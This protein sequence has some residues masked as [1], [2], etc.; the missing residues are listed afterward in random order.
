MVSLQLRDSVHPGARSESNA[1][2]HQQPLRSDVWL[3]LQT[4]YAQ[5]L[6]RGRDVKGKP[7][8]VGLI[9]FADRLRVIWHAAAANDPFADWWLIKIHDAIAAVDSRIKHERDALR[10]LADQNGAFV[11]VPAQMREPFRI[12]LQFAS[13]YAYKA[14]QMLAQFD[15]FACDSLTARH[16]GSLTRQHCVSNIHSVASRIRGVFNI[17][18]RFRHL[19]IDREDR[20][21]WQAKGETA[22]RFMGQIPIDVLKGS[23]RAAF[24][25]PIV[26]GKEESVPPVFEI[27]NGMEGFDL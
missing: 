9:V 20:T 13:P 10:H 27:E 26:L 8:I 14:A 5:L 2:H 6:V 16:V 4:R 18:G 11:A 3:T 1:P 12:K 15:A 23:R 21:S 25:P 17:P 24:A 22:Q 19:G 7:P